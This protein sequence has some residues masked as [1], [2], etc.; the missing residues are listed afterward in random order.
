MQELHLVICSGLE[1]LTLQF[2]P[3]KLTRRQ[4][5]LIIVYIAEAVIG[6]GIWDIYS[7]SPPVE[8][9]QPNTAPVKYSSKPSVNIGCDRIVW[10][11]TEVRLSA[12]T[13]LR[14]PRFQWIMDNKTLGTERELAYTFSQGK[15][16]VL[17]KAESGNDSVQD[18]MDILVVSSTEGI[19]AEV[20][21][22]SMINERVFMTKWN[23]AE[24]SIDGVSVILDGKDMGF[25]PQCRKLTVSGLYPGTH[26]WKAVYRGGDIGGGSFNLEAVTSVRMTRIDIARS[27]RAGD[28]VEGRILLQN[29]GTVPV[30]QFS[31]KTLVVNHKFEWMG[32]VARKEFTN[33]FDY[34]LV[35]GNSVEIPVRVAIPEKISGVKPVGDYSITIQLIIN[36][37]VEETQTV[38]TVVV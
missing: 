4:V 20:V 31:I 37:K 16:T 10:K 11:D 34:E 2:D 13:N 21:G 22:G 25:I 26:T 32:D 33:N 35:P 3:R 29:K 36:N 7:S 12:S 9:I 14:S 30:K 24:Y 1:A 23:D 28:T 6:Y 8:N 15:N 19:S 27:Y 38:K 18:N 5:I 17:L